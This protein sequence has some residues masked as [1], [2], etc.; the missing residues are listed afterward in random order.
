MKS[1]TTHLK[2][3]QSS[4]SSSF[5]IDTNNLHS[6]RPK[7]NFVAFVI[8]LLTGS[9][10]ALAIAIA[11]PPGSQAPAK[12][13]FPMPRLFPAPSGPVNLGDPLPGLTPAELSLFGEGLDEFENVETPQGGLGPI[14]NNVSCVACH[15]SGGTGGGSAIMV[16]R[17]GR[18]SNG[19]FDPLEAL[20]GSLLQDNA[21]DPAAQEIIPADANIIGNRQSTPLFGLGLIEAIPDD[22]IL[23]NSLRP[24]ID[25]IR[26]KVARVAD[27]A[28]GNQRIGRFG[29]KCQQATLLSFSG[30]AYLNEMGITNR[31]F[32]KENAPNGDL[33]LLTNYDKVADVE[34]ATNP[35]TGRSDI[36]AAADFMRLLAPPRPLP[37]TASSNMGKQIFQQ[38]NCAVCHMPS[39]NTGPNAIRAL[40]RKPVFLYSD[41]LLHDM[42]SL[43]D[44]IVQAA[45]GANE[46]RTAPLW[47]LRASAPYLHDGRAPSIDMAIRLHEGEAKNS[48]DRYLRLNLTQKQQILDFLK[49]L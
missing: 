43:G 10:M 31:L 15:N 20:G 45:A 14:F 41:L 46:F 22:A 30:D 44:G 39:M 49:S 21:I 40:D 32:P 4:I 35:E 2:I 6:L 17:F 12:R 23:R 27:V 26:G 8:R 3:G 19:K 9:S 48:R 47:G 28:S 34:D 18:L 7:S 36:D 1:K 25:G 29:W 33:N 16:T 11:N 24:M 42:G 38:I 5:E 37:P 13:P